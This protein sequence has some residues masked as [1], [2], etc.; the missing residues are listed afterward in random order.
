MKRVIGV[1]T[2]LLFVLC[3]IQPSYS[4][5]LR[6]QWSSAKKEAAGKFKKE[7]SN[8]T[9]GLKEKLKKK[10]LKKKLK[11]LALEKGNNL[12][13]Y[14][15]FDQDLGPTL[16][17]LQKRSSSV[18]KF[19][20]HIRDTT[21]DV[22]KIFKNKKLKKIFKQVCE[23]LY[24]MENYNYLSKGY[25]SKYKAQ[26][27]EF[28]KTGSRQEINIGAKL[29]NDWK[30]AYENKTLKKKGK[31]LAKDAHAEILKMMDGNWTGTEANKWMNGKGKSLVYGKSEAKIEKLTNKANK[32]LEEYR[33][34]V[35][36]HKME[37]KKSG[38]VKKALKPLSSA[39][40]RIKTEINK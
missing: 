22:K 37:W 27:N 18:N 15:D 32:I 13:S 20:D 23:D 5:E 7:Y 38:D 31:E 4:G 17:K 40:K 30:A 24:W 9:K 10:E 6:S 39:L 3:L 21:G 35:K 2:V 36:G 14:L 28:I 16:D 8:L 1:F 19:K 11:S 29:R 12:F 34:E 33:K 26:Y 25:K